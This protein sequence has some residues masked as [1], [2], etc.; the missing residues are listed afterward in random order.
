MP[1]FLI[2]DDDEVAHAFLRHV[3]LALGEVS[4]AFSGQGAVEACGRALDEGRPFDVVF[5]DVLMPGMDGVQTLNAVQARHDEAGAKRP[6][7][8]LATCLSLSTPP[9]DALPPGPHWTHLHK[10]FDRR[11]ALAALGV[12]GLAQ[13]PAAEEGEDF[14]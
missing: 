7:F 3:L 2:T 12:L 11:E 6:G 1:R 4:H 8:V 13:P 14:W 9:L 5:L 10:P